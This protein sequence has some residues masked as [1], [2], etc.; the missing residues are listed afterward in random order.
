MSTLPRLRL[1]IRLLRSLGGRFLAAT[2]ALTSPLLAQ[3]VEEEIGLVADVA[4]EIGLV[5][6]VAAEIGL[7]ADVAAE[8]GLVA[9]VAAEIGLVADV[10]VDVA[11]EEEE[12]DEAE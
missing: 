11:A 7:V 2:F 5:A 8:I 10:V 12:V 3:E 4:A 9:D 1:R 6:D